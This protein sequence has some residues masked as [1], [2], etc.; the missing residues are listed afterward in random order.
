M[1]LSMAATLQTEV[2][3]DDRQV[4]ADILESLFKTM[5]EDDAAGESDA[6]WNDETTT[7]IST[8]FVLAAR[9][10]AKGRGEIQIGKAL[11]GQDVS[12]QGLRLATAADW[13]EAMTDREVMALLLGVVP[14]G[15][16]K[17]YAAMREDG[18]DH[19]S[20]LAILKLASKPQQA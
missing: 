1:R 3:Q 20:T 4:A 12:L 6:V 11:L 2:S 9:R 15:M 13:A 5:R 10:L 17:Q 16:D 19:P 8:V 14:S 7:R 18:G